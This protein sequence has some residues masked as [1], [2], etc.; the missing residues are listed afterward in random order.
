MYAD[1]ESN[2]CPVERLKLYF[3]RTAETNNSLFPLPLKNW[4]NSSK[5]WYCN[6]KNLG[7][8]SLDVMMKQISS[9][10]RLS[11]TYTNHCVRVTVVTELKQKGHGNDEIATIT[12]HKNPESVNRYSK[13]YSD[14][15]KRS[16]SENLQQSF[17]TR[18]ISINQNSVTDNKNIVC[19]S[20]PA[21]QVLDVK[22][23]GPF[24]NCV[25]NVT[26]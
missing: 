16:L 26:K 24:H 10:A 25:F 18:R 14:A 22:F 1:K 5:I 8:R 15:Q 4:N 2:R 3:S 19:F 6:N 11:K 7:R 9:G 21:E 20:R 12:G 17:K 23:C 13:S